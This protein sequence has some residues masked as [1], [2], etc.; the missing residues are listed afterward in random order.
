MSFDPAHLPAGAGP[1]LT[2][3]HLAT[4]TT[5]RADGSPHVTPVGFTWEP[6]RRLV[7]VICS[8]HSV[9]ARNAAR[10]G[11]AALAVVDGRHWLTLEG[12]CAVHTD[13]A[14][15]RD[16]ENRYALRYRPPR[17]NPAR[18]VVVIEVDRVIGHVPDD[19]GDGA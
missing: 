17:D 2:E 19:P 5:L 7:R 8:G 14:A 11:R 10:A 1:L 13:A 6:Q 9:K 3:R 12:S 18:V 16:A 4:L 15:V